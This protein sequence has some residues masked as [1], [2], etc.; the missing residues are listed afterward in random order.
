M[1]APGLV[2][3]LLIKLLARDKGRVPHPE[4]QDGPRGTLSIVV[5]P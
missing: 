5:V 2:T 3:D 1:E 4:K